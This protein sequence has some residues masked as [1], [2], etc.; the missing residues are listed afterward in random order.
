MLDAVETAIE[1]NEKTL[2]EN[3]FSLKSVEPKTPVANNDNNDNVKTEMIEKSET[4]IK[5][6]NNDKILKIDEIC[7][8]NLMEYKEKQLTE[9]MIVETS[10]NTADMTKD[11][12]SNQSETRSLID[13][14]DD[15]D[16]ENTNCKVIGYS[17]KT[18]ENHQQNLNDENFA[19]STPK[20]QGNNKSIKQQQQRTPLMSISNSPLVRKQIPK[21]HPI[22]K[23]RITNVQRKLKKQPSTPMTPLNRNQI[24]QNLIT[25]DKENY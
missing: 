6:E 10:T 9:S 19:A 18:I 7:D 8:W 16:I 22:N 20:K 15:E 12:M 2:I 24:Q 17:V 13:Y 23:K 5:N 11:S 25:F 4:I 21:N 3:D 14:D 1:C